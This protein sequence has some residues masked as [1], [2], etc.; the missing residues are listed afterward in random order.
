M[1]ERG[2]TLL[3]LLWSTVVAGLILVSSFSCYLL[4]E[5][6]EQDSYLQT[7]INQEARMF[8]LSIEREI[9]NG[10]GFKVSNGKLIFYDSLGNQ[11]SYEK[12]G[13]NVRRQVNNTGHV[14]LVADVETITFQ[15]LPQGCRINFTLKKNGVG[16]SGDIT[17]TSRVT[18][19]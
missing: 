17:L 15:A 16:W 5:K 3:E 10:H 18:L 8:I 12:W 6:Q 19:P 1:N 14:I 2:F 11:M 4:L 13:N 7:L 9:Y